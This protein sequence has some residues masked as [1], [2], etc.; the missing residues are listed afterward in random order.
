MSEDVGASKFPDPSALKPGYARGV[1]YIWYAEFN[2]QFGAHCTTEL[3]ASKSTLNRCGNLPV[4]PLLSEAT[5]WLTAACNVAE[6][7]LCLGSCG[8]S[9]N[10]RSLLDSCRMDNVC[11]ISSS[12]NLE[13]REY[14]EDKSNAVKS[15]VDNT[16]IV[17]GI[18][19]LSNGNLVIE[20]IFLLNSIGK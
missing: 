11:G 7:K 6:E 9:Q 12:G 14:T 10:T 17:S 20:Y 8:V 15:E 16:C 18:A 2:P 19:V 13:G 4:A 1:K 3:A 5:P